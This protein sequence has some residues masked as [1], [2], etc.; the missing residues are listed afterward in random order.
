MADSWEESEDIVLAPVAKPMLRADAPSFSFNPGASQF[1]PVQLTPAARE[2]GAPP[3]AA[4]AAA[5]FQQTAP[6]PPHLAARPQV[7][8]VMEDAQPAHDDA[9][10]E[11]EADRLTPGQQLPHALL[12]RVLHILP[13]SR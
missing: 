7:D 1:S 10:M 11:A 4:P 5:S 13:A 3:G 9:V 12:P 8:C 6:P 2:A